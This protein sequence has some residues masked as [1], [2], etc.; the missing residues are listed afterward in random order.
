MILGGKSFDFFSSSGH[1]RF[2]RLTT[3]RINSHKALSTHI[4]SIEDIVITTLEEW[5]R[6]DQ[7]I[8]FADETNRVA[9][10]VII[11]IFLGSACDASV[12]AEI[13]KHYTCLFNGLFC[14]AINIP[15]FTFHKAV[16]ARKMLVKFIQGVFVKSTR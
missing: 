3:R 4:G 8:L 2:R 6:R 15:G 9:F 11:T 10:K 1:K 7:P 13:E 16:K 5:S 14:S 12:I